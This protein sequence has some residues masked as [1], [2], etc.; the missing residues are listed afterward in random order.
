MPKVGTID[1]IKDYMGKLDDTLERLYQSYKKVNKFKRETEQKNRKKLIKRICGT[2]GSG[3][4]VI[5]AMAIAI[6]KAV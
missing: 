6:L 1:F 5:G 3:V 4:V 2:I